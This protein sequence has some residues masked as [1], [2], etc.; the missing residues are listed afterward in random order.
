MLAAAQRFYT[1]S[2]FVQVKESELSQAFEKCHLDTV[3]FCGSV[4]SIM[5]RGSF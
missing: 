4:H 1:K 5:K 3:F 2:G